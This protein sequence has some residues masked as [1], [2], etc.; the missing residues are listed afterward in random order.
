MRNHKKIV[1]TTDTYWP[2]IN[3]VTVAVEAFRR[4]LTRLGHEV[5]IIAPKYTR[6]PGGLLPA[7]DDHVFR[8]SGLSFPLSPED[9]LGYPAARFRITRLLQRLR[10]DVVHSHT[11]F[12]IGF[13]GKRYCRRSGVAHVMTCHTY[14]E[15]YLQTY[16]RIIPPSVA[17][18]IASAWSSSDSQSVDRMMVPSNF[19]KRLLLSYGVTTPIDVLPNGVDTEVFTMSPEERSIQAAHFR[20][21]LPEIAGRRLLLYA[22]RIAREK[23]IDFL[24]NALKRVIP[25]VPDVLLLLAGDGPYRAGLERRAHEEGLW[26]HVRFAGYLYRKQLT[27]AYSIADA[28]VFC[29]KT[30]TQGLVLVEAM[31]CRTP[32]V[33]L[34][35]RG[36]EDVIT[37][38]RGG[39]LLEEDE[40]L[41]AD[42]VLLLLQDEKERLIKRQEAWEAA[43]RWTIEKTT[44]QLLDV[45][46][47]AIAS[48][49]RALRRAAPRAAPHPFSIG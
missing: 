25:V 6:A 35:A 17:R 39:F 10:P 32:V 2:R 15:N 40:A 4:M 5:F 14:W 47:R 16:F 44:E 19:L 22:G 21:V 31:M 48:S 3:G 29:S 37:G 18:M 33:A 38:T 11:E 46:D 43:Q 13:A 24:F 45:Y 42:K 49:A 12:T 8:F 30:E 9:R 27:Y 34:R 1:M 7:D 36:T 26:P 23:N 20:R 41:F 28:F